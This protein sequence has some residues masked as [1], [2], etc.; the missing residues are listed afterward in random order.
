MEEVTVWTCGLCADKGARTEMLNKEQICAHVCKY[1]EAH[2]CPSRQKEHAEVLKRF[3]KTIVFIT[4]KE[5]IVCKCGLCADNGIREPI[6]SMEQIELHARSH[7]EEYVLPG[8][9]EKYAEDFQRF[10]DAISVKRLV[11]R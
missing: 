7:L 11:V 10:Y 2:V 3:Y 5:G 4:H 1:L 6:I 9:A 8:K